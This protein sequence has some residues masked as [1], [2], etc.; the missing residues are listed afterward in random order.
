MSIS[1]RRRILWMPILSEHDDEEITLA[2]TEALS[3]Q[4]SQKELIN[5]AISGAR[6]QL[7][8]SNNKSYKAG[9]YVLCWSNFRAR[10][11]FQTDLDKC[12]PS[13]HSSLLI[14]MYI[15]GCWEVLSPTR[16]ETSS[17][18]YQGRA[19]FNNIEMR[20]V[21]KFFFFC[22][23]RRRRKFTPFWQKH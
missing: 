23:A 18:A 12:R 21:I 7:L 13:L 9:E 6:N 5:L 10:K 11:K 1:I 17:E 20:A 4:L 22:K 14:Q 16:K 2:L 19:G 15:P 3:A 8:Y